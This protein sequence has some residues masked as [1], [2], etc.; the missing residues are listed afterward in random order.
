MMVFRVY[1]MKQS[2]W[3]VF[4]SMKLDL[5]LFELR[6]NFEESVMERLSIR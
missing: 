5:R 6:L 3:D 2:I 4:R 1:R